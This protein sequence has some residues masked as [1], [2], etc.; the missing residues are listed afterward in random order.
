MSVLYAI[1]CDDG[2]KGWIADAYGTYANPDLSGLLMKMKDKRAQKKK[3]EIGLE[4]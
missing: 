1:S 4:H 2:T 3:Q